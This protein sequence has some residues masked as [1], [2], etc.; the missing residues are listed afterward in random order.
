MV[1]VNGG[2]N[3]RRAG[4]NLPPVSVNDIKVKNGDLVLATY[5]RG[6]VIM[7]D[8]VFLERLTEDVLEEDAHLFPIREAEQYYRNNRDL[9]NKAARFAGE[10]PEYGAV[11][12]YY[13]R[14]GP[15]RDSSSDTT[16]VSVQIL[17]GSGA[18]IRELDGPDGQGFN[19][20]AW[21]LRRPA[22]SAAAGGEEQRRRPEMIEVEPGRYTVR[23]TARGKE[24]AQPVTV[25]PDRRR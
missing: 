25:V 18:V 1:S 3:W 13:L 19:R 8:I 15:P 22:D 11:I 14:E 6:I 23:L 7:D 17:D 9:S 2:E 16:G 4:G 12:T 10:N 20:I 5:G 24:M 21:D